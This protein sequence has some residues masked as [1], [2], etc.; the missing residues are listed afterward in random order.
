MDVLV[1]VR[2]RNSNT[3]LYRVS[4]VDTLEEARLAILKQVPYHMV[5]ILACK[6]NNSIGVIK[7]ES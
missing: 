4:D 5:S 1:A 3:N 6:I 7:C 2:Y